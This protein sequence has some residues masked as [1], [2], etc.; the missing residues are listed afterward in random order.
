MVVCVSRSKAP[1]AGSC[2]TAEAVNLAGREPGAVEQH[3][4]GQQVSRGT[5]LCEGLYL[6]QRDRYYP[7]EDNLDDRRA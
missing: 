7:R 6:A 2:W 3:L 4:P 5:T 1:I